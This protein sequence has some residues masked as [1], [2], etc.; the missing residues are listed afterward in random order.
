MEYSELEAEV[1]SLDVT[2][3]ETLL[4]MLVLC[5]VVTVDD[6]VVVTL[7]VALD[8]RELVTVVVCDRVADDEPVVVALE[9]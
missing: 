4:V 2:E 6:G 9:V 7:D 1:V 8:V 5:D 3:L